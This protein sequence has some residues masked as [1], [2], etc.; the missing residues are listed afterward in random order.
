MRTR[1]LLSISAS[2]LAST[3]GVAVQPAFAQV[4]AIASYDL[5]PTTEDLDSAP[6]YSNI[7][8]G[9]AV[10]VDGKRVAIGMPAHNGVGRVGIYQRTTEG[11]R[12]TATLTASNP[13]DLEFGSA[14]DLDGHSVAIAARGAAYLFRQHEGTWRQI[15]RVAVGNPDWTRETNVAFDDGVLAVS[16]LSYGEDGGHPGKV[17][18]YERRPKHGLR[19]IATLR[20]SDGVPDDFFGANVAMERGVLVVGSPASAYVFVQQGQHWIERQKLIG[21]AASGLNDHF[22][23]SMA[24]RHR[25]ILTSS[26]YLNLPGEENTQAP[27]G[28]GYVF[29]PYRGG[30][31]QSQALNDDGQFYALFGENV[32]MGGGMVA[33]TT[34]IFEGVLSTE[35]SVLV[36]DWVGQELRFGREAVRTPEGWRAVDLDFSGRTLIVGMLEYR[37]AAPN[38]IGA[39]R[40]VEFAKD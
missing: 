27:E 26:A 10:A 33:V 29:L 37:Y 6:M 35:G 23:D 22:G 20:A 13:N 31:A 36:F 28:N 38:M 24:I 32:A 25:A 21:S 15:G 30:W 2:L 5:A 34:P 4:P 12:R 18:L 16:T 19:R 1:T 7:E 9:A 40:I 11:W 3:L 17:Q 14:I 8:F 39:V